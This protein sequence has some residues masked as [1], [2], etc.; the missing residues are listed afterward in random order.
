MERIRAWADGDDTR[1]IF[2][3]RG[4]AGTGK[5][6][7]ART[8]AHENYIRKRL[9]ASFFFSRGGGDIGDASKFFTSIAVQLANNARPLRRYICEAIME[10]GDIATQS[11]RDQ[12]RQLVLDPLS[13]LNDK[14][15]PLSY[16][17][18]VDALDECQVSNGC[19]VRFLSEIF[20]LQDKCQA[21]LFATSRFIPEII[22]KFEESIVLEICATEQDVRLVDQ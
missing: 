17:L 6:T 5:S 14:S 19:R 8:V 4:L 13:K 2:W 22:K 16:I 3:L 20:N 12:W 11:L 21:S 1:H 18:V 9:G 10:R 7:I 15:C